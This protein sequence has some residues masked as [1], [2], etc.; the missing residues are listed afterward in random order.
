MSSIITRNLITNIE[1]RNRG[2]NIIFK[3]QADIDKI[4]HKVKAFGGGAVREWIL[5]KN[6]KIIESRDTV[7]VIS[8]KTLKLCNDEKAIGL[9][10]DTTFYSIDFI[11]VDTSEVNNMKGMFAYCKARRIN[12][13]CFDTSNVILMCS[14]FDNCWA[15][16]I[17]ISHFDISK[18]ITMDY[19]FRNCRAKEIKLFKEPIRDNVE[20]FF[21]FKNCNAKLI[22]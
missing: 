6:V 9:F 18:V 12:I 2:K 3:S 15:D 4:K 17:D 1:E 13:N 8:E 10:A 14:M 11:G 19:M 16:Y 20:T 5:D 21:I 22:K 7:Y